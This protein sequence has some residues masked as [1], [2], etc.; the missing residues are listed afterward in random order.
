MKRKFPHYQQPDQKAC[1]PTCLRII[2]K[3]YSKSLSLGQINQVVEANRLGTSLS[4]LGEAAE[5]LGFRS[6]G[7]KT[8][9]GKLLEEKPYP[10]IAFWNQNHFVVVYA[11]DE[12]HVYVSDPGHGRLT[13]THAE[14]LQGWAG[15]AAQDMETQGI[16]LLLQPTPAFHTEDWEE[17]APKN[18]FRYLFRYLFQYRAFLTQLIL[19]LLGAS[20]LQ[21]IFPFLTQSLVDLGIQ[22][23]DMGLIYLIL[24]AQL[25]VFLGKSSL[26]FIRSWILL[27]LSTRIN[28]SILSDFF[29][30]LMKLPISFF[31]SKLTGDL[32]QRI[33]DHHRLEKLLTSTSL[34]TLFSVFTL[35]IFGAVLGWYS[36]MLFLVFLLGTLVYF[37][38]VL[39]FFK[40]R[41]DLDYKQFQQVAQ[42]QSKVIELIHGMQEIKLNNAEQHMRWGWEHLQARLFKLSIKSLSLQQKQTLGS[43][44]VNE[45][46]NILITFLAASLVV[47]GEMT[48]G[49]MLAVSYIIGQLNSPVSQLVGLMTSVQDAT[50]SLDRLGEIHDRTDEEPEGSKL[51]TGLPDQADIQ[52]K[53]V[54]FSYPGMKQPVLQGLDL[55]IPAHKTTAI[56]GVSGSGKTTLMKMLLGFYAPDEGEITLGGINLQAISPKAWR[57][58]CGTVMQEGY[59][60]NSSVSENIAVGEELIDDE[61]LTFATQLACIDDFIA[62]L[63]MGYH[64][65]I[66]MEGIGISTGQ[67]QRIQIARA[68]YKQPE[69]IFFDEATS[70]LDANNERKIMENL[71]AFFKDRTAIVIAHR[72]ST[73]QHADQIVVLEKGRIAEKGS[74]ETLLEQ[75]G[76]YY[77]L[78]K[79]QLQLERLHD[80]SGVSQTEPNGNPYA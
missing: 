31:D 40:R 38:W 59:I 68:I 33:N 49:M 17:V 22:N 71:K 18:S 35:I 76:A 32:M 47:S 66:G 25:M 75:R 60:F 48:L 16:A 79:N 74:H 34:S 11:A 73:V 63:P 69:F 28:I 43:S 13:Y 15:S 26:E 51:I 78:V 62:N 80:E 30:K 54:S 8:R 72:L 70:A 19:G 9:F 27:H 39:L 65:G 46:K 55:E 77:H 20:A 52:L 42:E 5:K 41:R 56:V 1:G 64:T 53:G 57:E 50:I 23:Q 12:Q 45:L 3:H 36:G 44:F 7:V 4:S 2:A 21:L 37:A 10:F 6:L 24:V 14:F 61:R 67:K 58:R 29:M